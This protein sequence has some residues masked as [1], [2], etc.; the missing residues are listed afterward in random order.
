MGVQQHR[1]S[2][3]RVRTHRSAV[4]KMEVPKYV[5]CS[6]CQ[7]VKMPHRLCPSCG[8]YNEKITIAPVV[9]EE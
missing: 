9:K 4:M 6:K 2:K 3:A 8:Y 7:E 1:H 5:T